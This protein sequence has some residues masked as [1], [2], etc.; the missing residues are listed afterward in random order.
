MPRLMFP[1][2]GFAVQYREYSISILLLESILSCIVSY[3]N[4]L[5]TRVEN[6]V[7]GTVSYLRLRSVWGRLYPHCT[8]VLCTGEV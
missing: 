5:L 3:P 1:L 7:P 2:P 4:R 8:N 6:A